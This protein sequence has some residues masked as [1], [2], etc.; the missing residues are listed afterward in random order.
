M[1]TKYTKGEWYVRP[2]ISIK[3]F[4]SKFYVVTDGNKCSECGLGGDHR[5]IC[6]ILESAVG[7]IQ[8][9]ANAKLIAV[10]PDLLEVLNEFIHSVEH[11]GV[12]RG[13]IVDSIKNAKQIIKKA[14]E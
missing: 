14:T 2:D 13:R 5:H 4:E 7:I 10:A 3:K 11:E 8:A 1:K 6:V 9:K 12:I